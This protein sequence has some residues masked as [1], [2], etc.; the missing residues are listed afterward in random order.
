MSFESIKRANSMFH[1]L[2]LM[3]YEVGVTPTAFQEDVTFKRAVAAN[4]PAYEFSWSVDYTGGD[5]QKGVV[6]IV[7][8]TRAQEDGKDRYSRVDATCQV[9]TALWN[10]RM[11]TSEGV[12]NEKVFTDQKSTPNEELVTLI[13]N[14]G[15]YHRQILEKIKDREAAMAAAAV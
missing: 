6:S 5:D 2:T 9:T 13:N 7:F 4:F 15:S 8:C 12:V 1:S 10:I 11:S 3:F 14:A